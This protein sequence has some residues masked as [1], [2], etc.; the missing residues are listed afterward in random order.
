M[1]ALA[2]TCISCCAKQSNEQ[3][4]FWVYYKF[5]LLLR[6]EN[7]NCTYLYCA[8]RNS[9]IHIELAS[10]TH[11]KLNIFI[12]NKILEACHEEKPLPPRT[13]LNIR[14][15]RQSQVRRILIQSSPV[16]RLSYLLLAFNPFL[17]DCKTTFSRIFYIFL[18]YFEI[19]KT[20]TWLLWQIH[21]LFYIKKH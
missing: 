20:W 16:R 4:L 9:I 8:V 14:C 2:W 1:N 12:F 7:S 19:F 18:C 13:G 10:S 6:R 5:I 17:P 21:I 15:H 3:K 11:E